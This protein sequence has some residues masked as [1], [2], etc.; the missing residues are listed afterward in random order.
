MQRHA[1]AIAGYEGLEVGQAS[2]QQVIDVR[3]AV[4]IVQQV[5]EHLTGVGGGLQGLPGL[6]CLDM[7]GKELAEHFC[8]DP[9]AHAQ[10]AW[11]VMVAGDQPP[12]GTVDDY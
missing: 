8:G 11:C 6:Q 9:L 4:G 12:K 2:A 5:V 3:C 1:N 7:Q 10:R